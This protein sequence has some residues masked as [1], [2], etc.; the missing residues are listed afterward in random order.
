MATAPTSSPTLTQD[1]QAL[2]DLI[3]LPAWVFDDVTLRF[4][5]VNEA[6]VA[7][8]GFSRDEFLRMTIA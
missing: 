8:Y 3:P 4:V 2:F 6:A 1:L 7:R 5:C